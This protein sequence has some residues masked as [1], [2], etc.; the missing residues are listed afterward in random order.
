MAGAKPQNPSSLLIAVNAAC[1]HQ[2]IVLTVLGSYSRRLPETLSKM[3][4]DCGGNITDC[5]MARLGGEFSALVMVSGN[6]DVIAKIEDLL[7]K[8]ERELG[9]RILC[10]RTEQRRP[11]EGM[12]YAIDVVC[13]DRPGVVHDISRFMSEHDMEIQ[14]M[15]TTTYQPLQSGT[16]MFSLHM[17]VSIPV[18]A[19]ISALRGE[20]LDFCDRLNLDAIMEPAK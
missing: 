15:Y 16:T 10:G 19:S 2:F 20:F 17:T 13:S 3:L 18:D 6:W 14:D 11:G 5:R 12:P 1:M 7:P 9:V 4:R 8:M